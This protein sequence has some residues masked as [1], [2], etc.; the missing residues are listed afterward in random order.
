MSTLPDKNQILEWIREHPGETSKR[1]VARAFGI[2]G[3]DRIELKRIL[4]ELEAEGEI[5]KAG[6]HIQHPEGLPPVSV[7]RV[8]GPDRAGDLWA[9]PAQ[10]EEPG[11]PPRILLRLRSHEPALGEGDRILARLSPQEDEG[12]AY[13]GRLIR[14][15]GQGP[16]K[17]IGIF[18]E[19]EEGGRI[20][21]IERKQGH[22]WIVPRGERHGARDGELVEAEQS[23][24]R[25]RLGM[26]RARVVRRL[27]DPTA[28]R[29]VSLI[30]IHA[31]GIPD[32]FPEETLTEAE[33]QAARPVGPGSRTDLRHLPL[34]TIDPADARDHDDAVC[35]LPDPENEGGHLVWV[36][37]ADVAHYVRP[38]SALDREARNRGNSTYFP[39]RV[40]PMLPETL[41]GDLCSLHEGVD[42]ACIAVEMRLDADGRRIGHRFVRGLMRSPAALTY[43]QVQRAVDGTP[44]EATEPLVEPV[45]KPLWAAYQAAAEA[46]ER[47]APLHLDLPERKIVLDPEGTVLSVAFRDRLEAHKLIEE[48]M[49]LANVCAAETL[50]KKRTP[51]LYRVHEEPDAEKLDSLRDVAEASGLTLAKGQVLT[52]RSLNKLLDAAA[53]REVAELIN[54]SVLRSMQQAYY[55]PQNFGHFGLAL[56]AYAH[57]TSPIRRYADLVVHRALVSAHGWG[58]DGLSPQE[59]E[60]LEATAEWI[61]GTERRSMQAERETT[62]RYLA[63]YLADRVGGEFAGRISGV[64]RFGVFVTLDETGADGLVPIGSLGGEYFHYDRDAQTLMG[65]RSGREIA[66]GQR[67][68]VRLAEAE[69]VT[70]GLLFEVLEIEGKAL[71]QG[72]SRRPSR[73]TPK[74]KLARDKAK[75]AKIARKIRRG[76][77]TRD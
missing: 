47:R 14:R 27:G 18:R 53:G 74:R 17:V 24:P 39:D 67:V 51:L 45:L 75:R 36:A 41:S 12:A 1:D 68:T 26:P 21:S 43:E 37:I 6:N 4:R 48:F 22:E 2:K 54:M 11:D 66:L 62:D 64:A 71:P 5:R 28:P 46:R 44:D 77:R 55:A 72:E 73:G 69:A 7:L 20:L 29:A 60:I 16:R 34:I 19:T 70:G 63:A 25:D 42:R 23:G 50:E 3:A 49:I 13:T 31:H 59:I 32:E 40:V 52:T 57:F 33:A 30:A 8:T 76:G 15:I 38:G 58:E 10:W 65:D 35:A 61:S 56:R 9:E